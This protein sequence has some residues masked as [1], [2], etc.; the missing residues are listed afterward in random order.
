M[1]ATPELQLLTAEG[2]G[3][4]A[5]LRISGAGASA[6]LRRAFLSGRWP[7]VGEVAYGELQD[8]AGA[9]VDDVL[10]TRVGEERY[11][12]GC[13]AGP[14]VQRRVL[15]ALQAA[16]ARPGSPPATLAD[17]VEEA[18]GRALSERACRLLL[19]QPELWERALELPG[20]LDAARA[21]VA[22]LE[23]SAVSRRLLEP[24]QVALRGAPN[25]GKSSLLNAL[26]G[27]TR[28]VVSDAPGTT[29]DAVRALALV[30]GLPVLL[31]DTAGD[32][33]TGDALERAG[34]ERARRASRSAA[35][36]LVVVD[37]REQGDPSWLH[38]EAEPRLV[39]RSKADLVAPEARAPGRWVSALEGEGLAE[40]AQTLAEQ[41]AP[42]ECLGGACVFTDRQAGWVRRAAAALEAEDLAAARRALLQVREEAGRG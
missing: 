25:A 16:G 30:D 13:H 36:R 5:L 9:R 20:D 22:A 41:L 6:V 37:G 32:R 10:V 14:A 23:R 28:A 31:V 2:A 42:E 12:L 4:V 33:D 7:E 3:G 24:C 18:L 8:L 15:A 19:A 27:R 35:L 29:R 1:N 21:Q 34:I 26:V 11:E 38:D 39:V 17:E 40:L